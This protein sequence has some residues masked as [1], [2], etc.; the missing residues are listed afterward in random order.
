MSPRWKRRLTSLAMIVTERFLLAVTIAV[1]ILVITRLPL[2]LDWDQSIVAT[3]PVLPYLPYE[4]W[5]PVLLT[6]VPVTLT[7]WFCWFRAYRILKK[8]LRMR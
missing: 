3:G 2:L 6:T 5:R 8:E 7:C 4:W 1:T